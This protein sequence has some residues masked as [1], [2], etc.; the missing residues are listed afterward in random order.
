MWKGNKGR[1]E[2]LEVRRKEKFEGKGKYWKEGI[3]KGRIDGGIG[4]GEKKK[5]GKTLRKEG[6]NVRK[7]R[8]EKERKG[9]NGK[10]T[11]RI[12]VNV[13]KG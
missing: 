4:E 6:N 12:C 9:K 2:I 13:E 8:E 3:E 1:G 7:G 5:G 10:R 11:G